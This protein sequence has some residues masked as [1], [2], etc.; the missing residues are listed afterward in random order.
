MIHKSDKPLAKLT[1]E[2]RDKINKIRGKKGDIT[3][4]LLKSRGFLG[5][6]L[7]THIPINYK[8]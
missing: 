6:V 5:N 1:K 8:I 2:R 3:T 7:K 4:I